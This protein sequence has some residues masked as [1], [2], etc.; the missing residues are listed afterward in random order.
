MLGEE[1]IKAAIVQRILVASDSVSK[2]HIASCEAQIRA[3]LY[4]LG[5]GEAPPRSSGDIATIC[6]SADIPVIENPDGTVEWPPD[7][8]E[9]HGFTIADDDVKPLASWIW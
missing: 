6:R 7:W 3:L 1:Q 8:L 4:V 9:S 2:S 5:D